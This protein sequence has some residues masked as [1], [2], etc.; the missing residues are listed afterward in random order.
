MNVIIRF[1]L[2]VLFVFLSFNLFSQVKENIKNT[3]QKELIQETNKSSSDKDI[4]YK[5]ASSG[6]SFSGLLRGILGLGVLVGIGFLFS[7][8]RKKISWRIV[9]LGLAAQ[10][11]IAIAVLKVEFIQMFF[12]FGGKVFVK[13][14]DFSK[15]GSSFLIKSFVSNNIEVGF[16][17]FLF[18]VLPTIIFFSAITSILYYYGVIQ[19]VVFGI[20]WLMKK[21]LKL[22]GPESLSAAGNIFLGQTESPLLIKAYLDKMTK[23][24][25]MLVMVGGMATIA[26]G[27]LALY[28]NFLG[29]N[30]PQE[31]LIFAKHLLTAS[32][33]AAPG[34]VVAAKLLVPQT[35][36]I[37]SELKINKDKI[38]NNILEA[39]A[40]GTTEGLKLAVNVGAML[41]VFLSLVALLNFIF[42]KVGDWTHLNILVSSITEGQYTEFSMQFI[43]GYVFAPISWL[44]GICKEDVALVGQLLGE[45]IIMN[46]LVAYTSLK[47]IMYGVKEVIFTEEKSLLM[48]TYI[49]CGFA[50]FGSIGIQIGGIGALAPGKRTMLSKLGLRALLGGTIASLLSGTI[51]GIIMG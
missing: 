40:N 27:V 32:I 45:K 19:K 31:Q 2:P 30:D 18:Q 13:I 37:D 3:E 15:E 11:L 39:I 44:I 24:E 34:A 7:T 6:F 51:V 20:A 8:N 17:N 5:K 22:S 1:L 28:I 4:K 48:S 47:D 36:K 35:E 42:I 14:L 38:G 16:I 49:L 21:I 25:I 41:L 23:S 46:E 12:E 26:G 50:N 10:I 33:M 43:L 9:L 29:G